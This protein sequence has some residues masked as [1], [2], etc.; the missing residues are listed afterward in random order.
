MTKHPA[1]VPENGVPHPIQLAADVGT[2]ALEA[3]QD[4]ATR[5]VTST[6]RLVRQYPLASV[7]V[8]FGGGAVL[9]I[10][11]YRLLVPRSVR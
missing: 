6:E 3:A 10:L 9:G 1:V 8:A 4:A 7:G 11:A 5:A 2:K